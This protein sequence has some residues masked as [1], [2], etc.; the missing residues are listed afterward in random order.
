MANLKNIIN[1]VEFD[2]DFGGEVPKYS[3][4]PAK[5]EKF[6]TPVFCWNMH[7][8]MLQTAKMKSLSN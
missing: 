6:L 1:S 4:L 5:L 7:P 8:T 2:P 3:I